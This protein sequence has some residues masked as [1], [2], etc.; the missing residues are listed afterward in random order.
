MENLIDIEGLDVVSGCETARP[1]EMMNVDGVT[2]SGVTLLII[3]DH[4]DEI[5]KYFNGAA[6]KQAVAMKMADKAGKVD[7]FMERSIDTREEKEIEGTAIRVKGWQGVKQ[8]YTP[9]LFKRVLAK[10]PHW[11]PQIVKASENIGNF[12]D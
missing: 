12:T 5:K 6:K 8:D 9:D 1:F 7:Q 2:G 11:I 10:N 4:A 3:G